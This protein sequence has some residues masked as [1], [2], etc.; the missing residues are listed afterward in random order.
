MRTFMAVRGKGKVGD[1]AVTF[2]ARNK[3]EARRLL[4]ENDMRDY[5]I[6]YDGD[7]GRQY[8]IDPA[9]RKVVKVK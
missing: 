5:T 4:D 7:I 3:K 9:T 8:A 1:D 6:V 2:E